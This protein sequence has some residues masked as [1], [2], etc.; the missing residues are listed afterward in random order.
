M[1]GLSRSKDVLQQFGTVEQMGAI[2]LLQTHYFTLI[3]KYQDAA[4]AFQAYM[5]SYTTSTGTSA[6]NNNNDDDDDEDKSPDYERGQCEDLVTCSK[7]EFLQGSFDH[8]IQYSKEASDLAVQSIDE[9]VSLRQ[10]CTMNALAISRD[11]WHWNISGLPHLIR[12]IKTMI[13]VMILRKI[14]I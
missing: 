12:K 8:A 7:L 10:G 3:G 4:Q 11:S 6:N 2:V 5:N 1:E 9:Y 14:Q 13:S